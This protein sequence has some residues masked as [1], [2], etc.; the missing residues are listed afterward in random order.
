M[1]TG[2]VNTSVFPDPVKAMPIM[3]R[4]ERLWAEDRLQVKFSR[5]QDLPITVLLRAPVHTHMV[6]MPWI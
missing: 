1:M 4:P 2:R 3:S 5:M 6:G